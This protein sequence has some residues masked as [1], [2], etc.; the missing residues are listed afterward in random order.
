METLRRRYDLVLID[1]S[2]ILD[3]ADALN[4]G[5]HAGSVFIVARAGITTEDEINES[6]KQ[7]NYA[8]ISPQGILF[9]DMLPRLGQTSIVSR[10]G[11]SPTLDL[12]G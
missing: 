7:L 6:I 12:A 10:H 9:N 8:G 2:P 3:V 1:T 5:A 11:N 4:T